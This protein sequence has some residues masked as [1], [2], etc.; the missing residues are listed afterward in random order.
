MS[1]QTLVVGQTSDHEHQ[2]GIETFLFLGHLPRT[3]LHCTRSTQIP[4]VLLEP[5]SKLALS[6]HHLQFAATP[7][8]SSYLIYIPRILTDTNFIERCACM[9]PASWIRYYYIS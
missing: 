7:D 6:P 4:I 5:R 8:F 1:L 2:K 3:A 9:G